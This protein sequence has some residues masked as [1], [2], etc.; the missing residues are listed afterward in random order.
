MLADAYYSQMAVFTGHYG[1]AFGP[2]G[3]RLEPWSPLKGK[4]VPLGLKYMGK[5]VKELQ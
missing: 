5:V 3:F 2:S 4:K 1:I